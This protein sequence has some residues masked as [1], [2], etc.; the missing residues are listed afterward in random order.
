[1]KVSARSAVS[2]LSRLLIHCWDTGRLKLSGRESKKEWTV[3][4]DLLGVHILKENFFFLPDLEFLL[5][6]LVMVTIGS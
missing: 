5:L 3:E 6:Y 4:Y 2:I 1:M